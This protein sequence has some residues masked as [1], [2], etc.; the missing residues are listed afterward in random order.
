MSRA[1]PRRAL[2]GG[3]TVLAMLLALL[4]FNLVQIGR[5]WERLGP[6][7]SGH[8]APD[9]SLPTLAG[10]PLR[11][12]EQRGRVLL[13]DFW[14][15]WCRPCMSSMPSLAALQRDLGPR[16]LQLLSI[17]VDGSADK[18]RPVSQVL[19]AAVPVLLDDGEVSQSYGVHVLPF[20]VL[21]GRDGET[22]QV[23]AGPVAEERLR[24]AAR[25]AL[26]G[27]PD[28]SRPSR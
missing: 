1:L 12:S 7:R 25:R 21:V 15:S 11:L 13:L 18:A 20:V 8:R 10:K 14:A 27:P 6:L 24:A 5:G 17:N 22:L 2:V 19:G 9:F 4:A 16:G 28:R 3:L 23:F 26:D